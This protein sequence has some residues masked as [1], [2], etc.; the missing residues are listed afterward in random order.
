[1]SVALSPVF[2]IALVLLL[3]TARSLALAFIGLAIAMQTALVAAGSPRW[4][5]LVL[6]C[7]KILE[8]RN[9]LV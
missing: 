8:S 9:K 1:V 4:S 3:R 5:G 2:W 6:L 7:Y